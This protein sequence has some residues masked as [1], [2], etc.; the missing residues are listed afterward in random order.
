M[1][2]LVEKLGGESVEAGG[3]VEEECVTRFAKDFDSGGFWA[4]GFQNLGLLLQAWANG[5]QDGA[6]AGENGVAPVLSG[7]WLVD[8]FPCCVLRHTHSGLKNG[9]EHFFVQWFTSESCDEAF[10]AT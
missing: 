3:F 5:V 9:F 2:D 7:V 8:C 6:F 10:E 4:F 1:P